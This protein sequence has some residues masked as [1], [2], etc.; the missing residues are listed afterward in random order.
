MHGAMTETGVLASSTV[1]LRSF[2]DPRG[3]FDA[4]RTWIFRG[5]RQYSHRRPSPCPHFITEAGPDAEHGLPAARRAAQLSGRRRLGPAK[6]VLEQRHTGNFSG[7]GKPGECAAFLPEW[8]CQGDL[9]TA[10]GTNMASVSVPATAS[11]TGSADPP[12]TTGGGRVCLRQ[13]GPCCHVVHRGYHRIRR[14]SRIRHGNLERHVDPSE[15]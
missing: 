5:Q 15:G 11:S 9:Q 10:T 14:S 8:P 7:S 12:T 6:D 3:P 1:S 2:R 4:A 13:R